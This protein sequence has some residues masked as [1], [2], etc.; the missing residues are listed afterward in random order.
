MRQVPESP[1]RQGRLAR[2]LYALSPTTVCPRHR[3][4][5]YPRSR[6]LARCEHARRARPSTAVRLI[7]CCARQPSFPGALG[8]AVFFVASSAVVLVLGLLLVYLL[9]PKDSPLRTTLSNVQSA[10]QTEPSVFRVPETPSEPKIDKEVLVK[11]YITNNASK[12]EKVRFS[13]WGPHMSGKELSD[14]Y[15][16]AIVVGQPTEEQKGEMKELESK[17]YIRVCYRTPTPRMFV[18]ERKVGDI[19]QPLPEWRE[20]DADHD[21]IYIVKGKIVEPVTDGPDV[22]NDT[23]IALEKLFGPQIQGDDWKTKF[24]RELA[25]SFPAIK[26]DRR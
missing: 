19:F 26:V 10:L 17:T 15:K 16:E 14:L 2:S 23:L 11:A 6:S 8:C 1:A 24:R 7:A 4:C 22:G 9:L 12:P 13:K 18:P 5:P 3:H 20:I 25:K 21:A